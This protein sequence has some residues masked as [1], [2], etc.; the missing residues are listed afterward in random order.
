MRYDSSFKH[1][2]PAVLK[3]VIILFIIP[4]S[5]ACCERGFS[6]QNLIK[7][8]L[9]STMSLRTLNCLMHIALYRILTTSNLPY[10]KLISMFRAGSASNHRHV[11]K[12]GIYTSINE[13]AKERAEN[14]YV[15][16]DALQRNVVS[17][18][19]SAT[20]IQDLVD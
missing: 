5:N 13:S 15:A 7:T 19:A 11:L 17:P 9:R 20:Y 8:N 2:F 12:E 10:Q 4:V 14:Q 3:L 18:A 6:I 16:E 1:D